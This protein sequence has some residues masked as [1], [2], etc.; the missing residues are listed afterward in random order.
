[1]K[2]IL[3]TAALLAATSAQADCFLKTG[4]ADVATTEIALETVK[5]ATEA[6]PLGYQGMIAAKVVTY[7]ALKNTNPETKK[8]I[9]NVVCPLQ[10]GL[11]GNNAAVF[12]LGAEPITTWLAPAIGLGVALLYIAGAKFGPVPD[13]DMYPDPQEVN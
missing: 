12:M 4:V 13:S 11:A 3:L 5:G 9:N 6:N 7:A 10:A 2:Q 1:M 8:Q